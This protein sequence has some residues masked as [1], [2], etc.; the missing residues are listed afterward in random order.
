MSTYA[1][2]TI[3]A[4]QAA[5]LTAADRV[6][7]PAGSAS[8][9][10][11]AYD[12]ND[13]VT[14]TAGGRTLTFSSALPAVSAAGNLVLSDGSSLFVGT[15][16]GDTAT[17]GAGSD[18]LFGGRG[19]D[20]LSG[21]ASGSGDL[22]QGNQGNDTLA[23]GPAADTLYGGQDADSMNGGGGANFVQGNRGAD[24]LQGGAGA[25]SLLGGRDD[26]VIAG[27]GG[28]DFMNGNL[29]EDSVLGGAGADTLRGEDG[30]DTLDGGAGEDVMTGG[31]GYD[32]FNVGLGQSN[33]AHGGAEL[34]LDWT[35]GDSLAFADGVVIPS[36]YLRLEAATPAEAR[37]LANAAIAS[38]EANYVA[39]Q[40][41]TDVLI[42][43]D[44]ANNNG[45]ADDAVILVGR[46]LADLIVNVPSGGG[47]G[48][49]I[50][51]VPTPG[52][53]SLPGGGGDDSVAGL[54]GGDSI[55][56]ETGNDTL[57]GGEGDDTLQG[58]AGNDS[59]TAG[60]GLDDLEGG[61]GNDT[62]SG[63]A[64]TIPDA[65]AASPAASEDAV[66]FQA[67]AL[68]D[69]LSPEFD[70]D[71]ANA[72]MVE[73]LAADAPSAKSG[74][75][76]ISSAGG[77]K[78]S[79]PAP[80]T[81]DGGAGDD[82]ILGGVGSDFIL[83]GTGNDT[84]A[85]HIP[86]TDFNDDDDIASAKSGFVSVSVN[87]GD[88]GGGG[89]KRNEAA[90]TINGGT[91]D[92]SILG[93]LGADLLIGGDGAD[94]IDGRG[95]GGRIIIKKL[96]DIEKLTDAVDRV[97]I[98]VRKFE[99]DTVQGGAG[100]DL[101]IAANFATVDGG[102]GNDTVN[103]ASGVTVA[104]GDGNDRF[105]VERYST[106]AFKGG[107]AVITDWSAGDSLE[108]ARGPGGSL[109]KLT[110]ADDEAAYE[111]AYAIISSG[112]GDYV[113]VQVGSD[114][115]LY[116]DTGGDDDLAD[117]V[118]LQGW[119]LADITRDRIVPAGIAP[120]SQSGDSGANALSGAGGDDSLG[121]AGGDDSLGGGG[122]NDSLSGGAGA[123]S[124]DGGD[125]GDSL[126]GGDG[127]DS[128]SGG[129]GN[130]TLDGG[131]SGAGLA[132]LSA[133]QGFIAINGGAGA[134]TADAGD[135]LSGGNGSDVLFGSAGGDSAQ[136]GSGNDAITGGDGADTLD[137][138]HDLDLVLGQDGADSIAGGAGND[139]LDGG[140]G[141]DT[142]DGGEE[143]DLVQGSDGADSL[144]GGTGYDTLIGG[145]GTDTLA[146]GTGSDQFN[147][148][149][150]PASTTTADVIIDW[151]W[152]DQL[153]FG[154]ELSGGYAELTA[155]TAPEALTAANALIASGAANVVA[156][157]V[158]SGVYV[159]TDSADDNGT[160]DA[161][162]FLIGR[163]LADIGATAFGGSLTPV[164]IIPGTSGADT[165]TGT[166]DGETLDALAGDDS[167]TAGDGADT[168]I[169]GPGAD[170]L[171]G[172]AG[173]DVFVLASGDSSGAAPDVINGFEYGTDLIATS[174]GRGLG[175]GNTSPAAN[176]ADAR[177]F[178][179]TA[180]TT[181]FQDYVVGQF[182]DGGGAST[183]VA[184]NTDG[185]FANGAELFFVLKD[186]AI[187]AAQSGG[188]F[189][190]SN[191]VDGTAAGESIV[192][193][194]V[195]D[196]IGAG[197]GDDTLNGGAGA[198]RDILS[199]GAGVDR[200]VI[201]LGQSPGTAS[202]NGFGS[203]AD[204]ISD[205]AAGETIAFASYANGGGYAELGGSYFVYADAKAAANALI[206][207]GTVNYVAAQVQST[208]YVFA[209]SAAN[210]GGADDVVAVTARTLADIDASAVG[211][212]STAILGTTDNDTVFSGAGT[213]DLILALE[214]HDYFAAGAGADT[215]LGGDGN[216]TILAE[217]GADSITGDAGNDSVGGGADN[218]TLDG[219]A[220]ADTLAGG[221]GADRLTG[222]AGSDRFNF[223][224]GEAGTTGGSAD[225]I[226]D[227]SGTDDSLD[228]AGAASTGADYIELSAADYAAAKALADAQIV[229]GTYN[230]VSVLVGSD[231]I[232]FADSGNDN[233]SAEDAVVLVGRALADIAAANFI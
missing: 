201:G 25:E 198:V 18:G 232:V 210:N 189:V 175:A 49:A 211:A 140:A 133:K 209:D 81:L 89:A 10:S 103:L 148:S 22:I 149:D 187:T 112:S 28:G 195:T 7:F 87:V 214:G 185:N 40:V 52:S 215:V 180:I 55:A 131:S 225:T 85:A 188:L 165:L 153:R 186:L 119:T 106:T 111:A 83:G 77:A 194:A 4:A 72:F 192:G 114:V 224:L 126:S 1:F 50:P 145:A 146:G 104:G 94:T 134:V 221:A 14:L 174:F 20:D 66:A 33:A 230:Y 213:D 157:Q 120:Q 233:G 57:D 123:D 54:G 163:T 68:W 5:A 170:T 51:V 13:T 122:G 113:A 32:R 102:S 132:K 80:D 155:A 29:G 160:A 183:L 64:P 204:R 217:A 121:G 59:L 101:I 97:G 124:L 154:S 67:T 212:T 65:I 16:G 73:L 23:G 110:A 191:G 166:A 168:V 226:A 39:V 222:G 70:L 47:G 147:L 82:S 181:G 164:A 152:D 38:G 2:E 98:P 156:A 228:F 79:L 136:G 45:V 218:D 93:G 3:T 27:G 6:T 78:G 91:G 179:T 142:V 205:W 61:D 15:P 193:A 41:G 44:S 227:W 171:A 36:Q 159:F 42:F 84:L 105:V 167:I 216:D 74:F 60:E 86:S 9:V 177:T 127:A 138:E 202:S 184:V 129:N 150:S 158:G 34:I 71:A 11:V 58:G 69:G 173:A 190:R 199:G 115:Y 118:I 139:T 116:A 8:G 161:G 99:E 229:T 141:N 135:T 96:T 130:D 76:S 143:D 196:N 21:G 62:L 90:D 95:L 207:T 151:A 75:A 48:G 117:I 24:T 144:A 125:G 12:T 197:D 30:A 35:Q 220:G 176:L 37:S 43:A 46:S 56:G 31:E 203:I 108:F 63:D 92:D 100:D 162:V 109:V 219:G 26:D 107:G 172:G 208:V 88:G 206:A 231:V 137:G 223:A 178:V 128:L 17:G 182:T 53:D 200:F 169:G 19:D